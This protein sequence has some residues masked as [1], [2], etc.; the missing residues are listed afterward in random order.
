[1]PLGVTL[2]DLRKELRAEI[3]H[4]LSIA[5]GVNFQDTLDAQLRKM[6]EELWAT[7]T[8]PHLIVRTEATLIAGQRYLDYPPKI[9]FAP[10]DS[11]WL[12]DGTSN[13]TELPYGIGPELFNGYDSEA[14]Q[15]SWPPQRWQNSV[16]FDVNNV[17][18][19]GDGQF[20]F[21]P[22]PSRAGKV[23]IM[24][25]ALLPPLIADADRCVLDSYA[26]T[27]FAASAILARQ[28]SE[29]AKVVLARAQEYLR[30][31]LGNQGGKKRRTRVLGGG[32]ASSPTARPYLDY[33]PMTG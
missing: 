13:Y 10:I 23:L 31:I 5:Q 17:M 18:I 27:M 16:K 15:R 19:P 7:H 6:Q 14:G 12:S 11:V 25:Q 30:R 3:G 22:I 4:S 2:A 28:K 32:S 20:E 9:Q 26:I 1:M 8:W 29:D 24:S 33:V 21:W